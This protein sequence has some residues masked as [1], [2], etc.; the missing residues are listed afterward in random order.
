MSRNASSIN[1]QLNRK[2][3]AYAAAATAA[4]GAGTFSAAHPAE[5]EVVYTKTH[6]GVN[7]GTPIDLNRDG[8]TDF[9]FA[10]IS[11]GSYGA[12][13]IVAAPAGNAFWGGRS[14]AAPLSF[15][16]PITPKGKF[17]TIEAQMAVFTFRFESFSSHSGGPWAGQINKYMGVRFTING[18]NHFGW[19]RITV[20]DLQAH[21]SGY[22]YESV[23]NKP[24][25]AGFTSGAAAE[26]AEM[27]G[28]ETQ[29]VV[30]TGA[31]LGM[32]G[33][34]ADAL[35]LWRRDETAIV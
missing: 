11:R 9:T 22:A 2:L 28:V 33:R 3:A 20:E 10:V 21:I 24:I 35:S 34:G 6:V 14:S 18:Q 25:K 30:R 27:S 17:G 26:T 31:T 1:P 15:G 23:A 19:I 5:A 7:S 16:F 13:L 32:L 4:I 8:I 12:V 29:R